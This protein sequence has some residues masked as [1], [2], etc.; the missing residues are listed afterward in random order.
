MF[1][2]R[3]ARSRTNKVDYI[4]INLNNVLNFLQTQQAPTIQVQKNFE[5]HSHTF[6]LLNKSSITIIK[7]LTK[8]KK[9]LKEI[10]V[11]FNHKTWQAGVRYDDN[12]EY[13]GGYNFERLDV[14]YGWDKSDKNLLYVVMDGGFDYSQNRHPYFLYD[15]QFNYVYERID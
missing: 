4:E 14:A 7:K 3:K 1:P 13:I 11:Q 6:P 5:Y 8:G 10:L 15:Y 9:M 2:V 12:L